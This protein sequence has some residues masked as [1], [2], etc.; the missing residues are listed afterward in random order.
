MNYR[1]QVT[2]IYSAHFEKIL[3]RS[4]GKFFVHPVEIF[5]LIHLQPDELI[6]LLSVDIFAVIVYWNLQNEQFIRQRKK[7]AFTD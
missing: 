2:L 4:Y 3:R 7:G 5:L 6:F 1:V